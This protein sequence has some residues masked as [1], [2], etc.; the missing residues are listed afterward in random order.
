MPTLIS[1]MIVAGSFYCFW[2][3]A[4]TATPRQMGNLLLVVAALISAGVLGFLAVTQRLP[5]ALVGLMVIWPLMASI[6]DARRRRLIRMHGE[7]HDHGYIEHD[8][9]DIPDPTTITVKVTYD[10]KTEFNKKS[11]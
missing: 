6:F 11:S 2:L 3:F 1:L 5:L 7:L 8:P 9:V 4:Q 10:I